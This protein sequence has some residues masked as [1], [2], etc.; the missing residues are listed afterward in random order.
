MNVPNVDFFSLNL[1]APMTAQNGVY[2]S[3][4][5]YLYAGPSL[6]VQRIRDA[7]AGQGSILPVAAPSV[8]STW[9]LDFN[10]P[11]LHCNPVS[12]EFRQEV[13]ANILN[14]TFARRQDTIQHDCTYGPGYM[15]WHPRMMTPDK[16][17][18]EYL[19]FNIDNW[20]SLSGALND[21]ITHGYP[22]NDTASVFLAI[23]PT[24]FSSTYVESTS[25]EHNDNLPTMCRG[26]PWYQ[27]GLAKYYNTSTVL[28]CDV[29]NSTYH[30]TFSFVNGVQEV[31]INKVTDITDTPMI[32]TGEVDV[33]FNSLNK[34]DMSLRPQACPPYG[35][36]PQNGFPNACLFEPLILSTL[37]YQGRHL[38][39]W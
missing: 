11:S 39:I 20:N 13:L 2:L 8:N 34:T 5:S 10:G 17:M 29:H 32:T 18:T 33:L 4:F 12:S 38:P 9:D 25:A 26:R 22:D 3:A 1:A 27:A 30:T 37:S 16:S 31:D 6:T 21:H 36:G 28:R 7:V 23:A 15:A 35:L 14:F 19:P 24:L